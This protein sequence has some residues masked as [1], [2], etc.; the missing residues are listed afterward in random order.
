MHHGNR[1][2][3]GIVTVVGHLEPVLPRR[4]V[5]DPDIIGSREHGKG[6]LRGKYQTVGIGITGLKGITGEWIDELDKSVGIVEHGSAVIT[7]KA[8][9]SKIG[10]ICGNGKR[11]SIRYLRY[12]RPDIIIQ[13]HTEI[14]GGGGRGLYSENSLVATIEPA[15]TASGTHTTGI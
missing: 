7:R 4:T 3:V 6:G 10:N 13:G 8:T 15:G 9:V 2:Q 14:L 11:L 5:E 12:R 1:Y